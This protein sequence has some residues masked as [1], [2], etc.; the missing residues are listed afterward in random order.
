MTAHRM[1]PLLRRPASADVL[2]DVVR[3][4]GLA[5]L[6]EDVHL[7]PRSPFL[8]HPLATAPVR[9]A[10]SAVSSWP[11]TVRTDP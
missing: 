11:P 9:A 8:G 10:G 7:A 2:D 6:R 5:R 1:V 3:T 4:A